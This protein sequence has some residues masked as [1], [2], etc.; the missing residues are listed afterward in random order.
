MYFPNQIPL[1]VFLFFILLAVV[2]YIAR[3]IKVKK[4]NNYQL[5]DLYVDDVIRKKFLKEVE[6][7]F[8]F[9]WILI[10]LGFVSMI[11]LALINKQ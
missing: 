9:Y 7:R 4:K 6:Y 5:G 8:S 2:I 11:V 10:I 3:L 1:F